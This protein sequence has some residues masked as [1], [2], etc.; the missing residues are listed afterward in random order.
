MGKVFARFRQD[1]QFDLKVDIPTSPDF[2]G[3]VL[4]DMLVRIRGWF[5]P[6]NY[7]QPDNNELYGILIDIENANERMA[8]DAK[9]SYK[10]IYA[11]QNEK[12]QREKERFEEYFKVKGKPIQKESWRSFRKGMYCLYIPTKKNVG[13]PGITPEHVKNEQIE[14]IKE[15]ISDMRKEWKKLWEKIVSLGG[16]YNSEF[17]NLHKNYLADEPHGRFE[18]IRSFLTNTINGEK[19]TAFKYKTMLEWFIEKDDLTSDEPTLGKSIRQLS[20]P[21]MEGATYQIQID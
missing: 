19:T 5:D 16:N 13:D 20:A 4:Q 12:D 3:Y 7:T 17:G 18:M 11:S 2:V 6:D 15:Y 1:I 10:E 8:S 21:F 9:M 14:L